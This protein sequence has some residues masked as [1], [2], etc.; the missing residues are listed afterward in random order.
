MAQD[1]EGGFLVLDGTDTIGGSFSQTRS[2]RALNIAAYA[3]RSF[4]FF[5]F[6]ANSSVSATMLV[7]MRFAPCADF[8]TALA[9]F[10]TTAKRFLSF[11]GSSQF[12]QLRPRTRHKLTQLLQLWAGV[13]NRGYCFHSIQSVKFNRPRVSVIID[14]FPH[15]LIQPIISRA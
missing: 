8:S 5:S 3:S 13:N 15:A 9:G 1:H 12:R 2:G 11:M 10:R 14:Y 7:K 6:F 4:R